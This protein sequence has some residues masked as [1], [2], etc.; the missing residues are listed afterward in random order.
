MSRHV[1][2]V[3][4]APAY[5]RLVCVSVRAADSYGTRDARPSSNDH[6]FHLSFWSTFSMYLYGRM[7][8]VNGE[9][10][11][12]VM[13]PSMRSARYVLDPR[14]TSGRCHLAWRLLRCRSVLMSLAAGPKMFS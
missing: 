6:T 12:S 3:I 13:R 14:S 1:N 5:D 2:F 4:S 10:V 8:V 11:V 7:M 9:D